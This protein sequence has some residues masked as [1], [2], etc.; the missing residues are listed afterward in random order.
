MYCVLPELRTPNVLHV[1]SDL[2]VRIANEY[3]RWYNSDYTNGHYVYGRG[4]CT[5]PVWA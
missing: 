5:S 3:H 4:S 2:L 1:L